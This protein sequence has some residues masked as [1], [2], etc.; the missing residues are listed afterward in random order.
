MTWRHLP[1]C[2]ACV[3]AIS[4]SALSGAFAQDSTRARAAEFQSIDEQ[5]LMRRITF[6]LQCNS[7]MGTIENVQILFTDVFDATR[8]LVRGN[9]SQQLGGNFRAFGFSS[10]EAMSGVFEAAVDRS[11][12]RLQHL[13]FKISVRG[14]WVKEACLR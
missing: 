2:C 5:M 7:S 3:L 4:C 9:Y 13:Q 11:N 10:A 12:G 14:G 1:I 8:V 6:A